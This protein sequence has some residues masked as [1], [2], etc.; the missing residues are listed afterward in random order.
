MPYTELSEYGS[1]VFVFEIP[2]PPSMRSCG[3]TMKSKFD[4]KLTRWNS[5]F[6]REPFSS[7]AVADRNTP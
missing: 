3:F 7:S 2:Q 5:L 1:R 4:R 6:G